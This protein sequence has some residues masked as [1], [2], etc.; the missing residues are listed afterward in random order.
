MPGS[1]LLP[2][3][4][5]PTITQAKFADLISPLLGLVV[6][7]TWRGHG[8]AIFLELGPLSRPPGNNPMGVATVMLEWSWRVEA[9]RSISFGS[10]STDRKIETGLAN[11]VGRR[12]EHIELFG[13]LPE[14]MLTLSGGQWVCSFATAEGQPEWAFLLGARGSL[15]VERGALTHK[16]S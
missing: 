7:H 5:V 10:F 1:L 8:S 9:A 11:L 15:S 6:T 4:P 16:E 13:R 3:A 12:I 2:L 14:V